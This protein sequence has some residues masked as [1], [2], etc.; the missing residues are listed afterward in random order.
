MTRRST[1]RGVAAGAATTLAVGALALLG[2][3]TAGAAPGS[4]TWDD[5]SSRFTRTVSNTTPAEGDTVT[6]TTKFDRTSWVDEFIYNVK[7]RHP[8]CL[9]YVPGSAKM[10]NSPANPEVNADE[11]NGTGYVRASWGVTS[12]VVQNRPGFH[13]SPTFS[14]DYKV[15]SNCPRG[16]ALATGMDYGGSLGSGNYGTKGPAITMAKNSSTTTLAPVPSARVGQPTTLTATV[17]G[18]APGNPV[19]FYDATTKIG[20]GSLDATGTATLAWTPAVKGGHTLSARFPDTA[21]ANG[22]QSAA[23]TI[24][25]SEQNANS[26]VTL[27]PVTGAQVGRAATITA[28]VNP[29]AAGGTIELLDGSASL[30]TIPVPADGRAIYQWIPA[31]A[32]SHTLH[33]TFSGRDGVAGSTTTQQVSVADAPAQSTNSTTTLSPVSGATVGKA[34]T[35][36]AKVNP[37]DAGGTVTFKNGNTVVGTAQV[38]ADG[39]ATTQWTPAAAGQSTVTAEYSGNGNV[40]AS[41]DQASVIVAP[42]GGNGNGAGSLD[43]LLGGFGSSK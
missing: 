14:V 25:V 20:Q 9:T 28:T 3:G 35:L 6:V 29:T 24:Q 33:A 16:T 41:S 4:I 36:T 21:Y 32:G 10:D 27:A 19:E 26:T 5:G 37:A 1:T 11:G 18:G 31:T 13:S 30:A 22:S 34:T 43:S 42:D 38:G 7:D 40:N 23:L 15:G 12:W 17:T 39:T 8:S 2:A